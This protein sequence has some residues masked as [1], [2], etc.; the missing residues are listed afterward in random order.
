MRGPRMP[1]SADGG[2]V[3]AGQDYL[4]LLGLAARVLGW[5]PAVF[6]A[7]TPRELLAALAPHV[8]GGAA[9]APLG[10]RELEALARRFPDRPPAPAGG[11]HG[12][13]PAH[14]HRR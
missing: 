10:R 3:A 13:H 1:E 14:H 7:A 8:S 2:R 12:P 4:A 9:P 6:W 11:A 5:P